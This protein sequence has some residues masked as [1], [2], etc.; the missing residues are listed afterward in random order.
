[1]AFLGP[2][3]ATQLLVRIGSTD[4]RYRMM[5]AL[6]TS[7]PVEGAGFVSFRYLDWLR[8]FSLAASST[9]R[10]SSANAA[11]SQYAMPT[12]TQ[13]MI[14][15]DLMAWVRILKHHC[16]TQ[17]KNKSSDILIYRFYIA[18]NAGSISVGVNFMSF[19]FKSIVIRRIGIGS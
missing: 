13:T 16:D 9:P 11:E 6:G 7:S 18:L 5:S 1:M 4:F 15:E 14:R 17:A 10:D 2:W 8:P 12:V 19:G 3:Q